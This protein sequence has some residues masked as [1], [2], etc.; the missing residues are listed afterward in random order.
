MFNTGLGLLF[1]VVNFCLVLIAYWRFGR[2]GLFVWIAFATVVAN[3]QVMKSIEIF[4]L[5]ATLGNTLYGSVFLATDILSERYGKK[6]AKRSVYLGFFS[7]ISLVIT[8]QL[9]LQFIPLTPGDPMHEALVTLFQPVW[10]IVVGSLVAYI[11]SQLL[12][13]TLF[14]LIKSKFPSQRFL[15][16]RNNGATWIAQLLDTA[17]FV[18]IAFWGVFELPVL[19]EIYLTTYLLKVIVAAL[20]TPFVY[21]AM[22]IHPH[23]TETTVEKSL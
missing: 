14:A 5:A 1:I 20:D 6:A 17:I 21:L 19:I 23:E 4:G 12:D 11:I 7:A 3:I 8:M 18:S 13:I 2:V 22:K 10:R 9:A 15:W 16:L